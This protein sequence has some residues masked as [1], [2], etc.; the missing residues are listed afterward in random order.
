MDARRHG[1]VFLR[2]AAHEASKDLKFGRVKGAN[3]APCRNRLFFQFSRLKILQAPLT[4]AHKPLRGAPM[5]RK[6]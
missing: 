3:E 2:H 4:P 6:V 5:N 1:G